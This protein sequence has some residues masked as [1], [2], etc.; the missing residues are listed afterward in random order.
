[1]CHKH[2]QMTFRLFLKSKKKDTRLDGLSVEEWEKILT[3]T[4]SHAE[5]LVGGHFNHKTSTYI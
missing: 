5:S 1:M 4:W 2:L 3:A